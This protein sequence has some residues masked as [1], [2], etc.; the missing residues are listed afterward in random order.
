MHTSEALELAVE[1]VSAGGQLATDRQSSVVEHSKPGTGSLTG[2][3]VTDVDLAVERAVDEALAARCPDDGLVG[4]EFVDRPGTSG[5]TWWVDPVDGTLNY[6]R[7]LGVWSVVLSA[8]QGDEPELVAVWSAGS[9]WTATRGGGAFCDGVRL[10]LPREAEPGGI[11]STGAVLAGVVQRAGWLARVVDS[12]A[13]Q[14]CQVADGRVV[15]SI[16]RYGHRRDL[17]GPAL[18][19]AEAGGTVTDTAGG[20]WDGES[21]GLVL[22]RAEAHADLLRLVGTDAT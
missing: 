1:L 2:A 5:R 4:E 15:G 6:A 11:V 9:L 7:R 3:A 12:S 8:W 20:A 21:P 10:S 14:V 16:R 17:H 22:G 13:A 19:V 18:L